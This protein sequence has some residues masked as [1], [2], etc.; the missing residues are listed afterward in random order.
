MAIV[1]HDVG[2]E[3]ARGRIDREILKCL[4][5]HP[6][7]ETILV[8]NKIDKVKNKQVLLDLI[9]QLTG[10]RLNNK[11]FVSE[12]KKKPRFK[13]A[14]FDYDAMFARTA[15]QLKIK[16]KNTEENSQIVDLMA[17]LKECEDFLLKNLEK[18]KVSE[19]ST[20][21][22]EQRIKE[23]EKARKENL[24]TLSKDNL[25]EKIKEISPVEFKKDLMQT[26]DWHLYYQKLSSIGRLIHGQT[27]WPY[28]NQVF[29][30]SA[31]QN[32]GV[33]D[34]R[35]YLLSRAQPG[36]WVFSRCLLTDQMPRQLAEDCVREKMLEH[37]PDEL[38]YVLQLETVFWEVND[39]GILSILINV[40]P[41]ANKTS[42][43]R[44]TKILLS[45]GAML[46]RRVAEDARQEL[47]RIFRSDV[48]LKL[49]VKV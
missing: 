19:E 23:N 2:D 11:S 22:I 41:G 10:G 5:T 32:D 39:K 33:E 1:V 48:R 8:L 37:L 42:V 31:S 26:T 35:R 44:Q 16:L 17:E 25:L 9:A 3:Y 6:E 49:N 7:K 46:L 43:K 18:I 34:L 47:E 15:E 29:M 36:P 13:N 40:I 27:H 4:F 24:P 12:Q 30:T 28:F 45:N 14:Q 20:S 38:G 21:E